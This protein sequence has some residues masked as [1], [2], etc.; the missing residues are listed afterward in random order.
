[1]KKTKLAFLLSHPVQYYSPLF[2]ELSKQPQIDLTILYCSDESIKEMKDKGFNKNIKLDIDL[3]K[4]YKYKFLKNYSPIKS[5]FKP[6]FGLM[7]FDISKEILKYD[8][9]I[10]HGWHYFTHWLAYKSAIKNKIPYFIRSENPLNQELLKPKWKRLIKK[11]ILKRIFEEASGF[12]AIG[13]ENKD[14]YKFYGVKEEKIFQTPYAVENERFIKEYNKLKNKKDEIKEEL[15]ISKNKTV[16]LFSGKLIDKKRPFDLLKAYEKLDYKNKALIF[17]GDGQLK[18]QL[19]DYIKQKNLKD[20]YFVGFKNQ[21][22]ISKYYLITD[23]FVLPSGIGETWGLVVNE[24]M[25]FSLPIIVSD[26]VGCGKDL[27]KHNKNGFI[28]KTGNIN[29]LSKY[30][31]RLLQNKKLREEMGKKSFGIIK[32]WSYKEDIEGILC[33]L[34]QKIE[35]QI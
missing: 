30:L 34:N 6:P 7:N 27:V 25:C 35:K 22:E 26:L 24:A 21:T 10:I 9:V 1:M 14:F 12:L 5:I 16:I 13:T 20:I 19:E 29:S 32:N 18:E 23:I 17:L 11:L 4:G 2:R 33:V 8:A 28:F 3:L 31:E 15:R